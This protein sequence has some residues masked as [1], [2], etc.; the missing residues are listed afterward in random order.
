LDTGYP[1]AQENQ[2]SRVAIA[3]AGIVG[4]SVAWRL[5]Q[6]GIAVTLFDAGVLGG[7][8]SSA[9]AGM[10]SPGGEFG[11]PSHWL[12]L[13]IAGMRL[14][15][16]FVEELRR[17]TGLSIDFQIGGCTHL[18]NTEEERRAA[19]ARAKFQSGVGIRVELTREGLYYPEDGSVDPV[20]LLRAL[21]AAC[22]ARQVRIVEKRRL[23]EIESSTYAAVVIAAGAWS[24]QIAVRYRNQPVTIPGTIPVKGHLLGFDLEPGTLGPMRRHGSTYVL[25][26][27]NGFT[28]AGSTEERA[29]FDRTVDAALCEE[30]HQR[31]AALFPRLANLTPSKRWIGFRPQSMEEQGPHIGRVEGTNVWLAYGHYRHGILLAPL[32]AQRIAGEVISSLGSGSQ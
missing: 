7:E 6:A 13:A 14:Y 23:E 10:L 18:A 12:D 21:R 9:A 30:I 8:A 1:I 24:G 26:R 20:E 4:A 28:I 11:K 27:S 25:Q 3:G 19:Q 22:E 5:S 16:A 29:G 2:A 15:P 17:E 31:A 32:T